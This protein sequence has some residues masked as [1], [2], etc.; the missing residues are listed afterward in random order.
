[1]TPSLDAQ[2]RCIEQELRRRRRTFPRQLT[3]GTLTQHLAAHELLT[4]EAVLDTLQALR[5][6]SRAAARDRQE[7]PHAP[8]SD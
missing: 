1:M 3:E 6:R 5:V 7:V 2:I 4:M 8:E